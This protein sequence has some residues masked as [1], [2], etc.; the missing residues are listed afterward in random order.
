VLVP[1]ASSAQQSPAP[2]ALVADTPGKTLAGATFTAPKE[3][4]E[5]QTAGVT[6]LTAPENDTALAIVDIAKA[7][8]AQDAVAQAWAAYRPSANY[9]VKLVSKLAPRDGWDERDVVDYETSPNDLL[10][11][12]AVALRRG[13]AWEVFLIDGHQGTAEKRAAA[14][15]LAFES[16]RPG[17]YQKET[18][19]GR[20]AHAL[21]AARIEELKSFIQTAM[22]EL[23]LPGV[24]IA[25]SDHGKVVFE[26]GFGVRELG[27]SARVD[28]NTLFMIASNTK[29][30]STLLLARL[31]D[32]GKLSWDEPVTK[33]YPAFRLGSP[34]TTKQVE[35]KELVCACTGL[36]RKDFEWIFRSKPTTP[37]SDTFVQLAATTPTSH[38]GEVFQYNNLMASA[39]G[40]IAGHLVYPKRELGA[41]YD[42]AMQAEIFGPL[43]MTST[44]LDYAQAVT[45]PDH[46]TPHGNDL[47]GATKIANPAINLQI[48]PYRPAGGAWSSV[49]DMIKYVQ[50]ELTPGRLPDG[51]QFISAKNVLQRRAPSVPIGENM[52]YGMGLMVDQTWGVPIIHH[53]GDL[54]GFHSDWFAFPDAGVGAVILTNGDDGYL[55]RAPFM[56]RILEVLYDGH[57]EAAAS[58]AAS[59]ANYKAA[60][61]KDRQRLVIPA[62][63]ALASKLAAHYK[64]ADL[65]HI[66]VVRKGSQL[67]FDFG[68]W[69][70]VVV[71]RVN[72]DKSVSFITG[73]PGVAGFEFVAGT[74][75]GRRTLTTRDGQHEYVYTEN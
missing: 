17:G 65:G 32:E 40:Y 5:A 11:V 62:D 14:I 70:S 34:Q 24:A 27:R 63:P 55:L 44:T 37:A 41:A 2:A 3:W 60:I 35:I 67:T 38:F 26:G 4:S 25:L 42:A 74:K 7:T 20:P 64:N 45:S 46:A 47:D 18:F 12:Q 72:D 8:G 54:T 28:A 9:P 10:A 39:A 61:A 33:V 58:I 53:G 50:E 68:A 21:D 49:H 16:L 71:S 56:R 75:N 22:K 51:R 13:E 19:A 29:G 36:P 15:G 43:G 6:V 31:V 52:Y 30:L 66:D 23:D 59:A 1:L 69:K 48:I 73:D 57:P